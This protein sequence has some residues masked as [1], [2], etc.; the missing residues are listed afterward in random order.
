MVSQKVLQIDLSFDNVI[1]NIKGVI[2]S[3]LV[4]VEFFEIGGWRVDFML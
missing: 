1:K 3:N 2:G 4:G